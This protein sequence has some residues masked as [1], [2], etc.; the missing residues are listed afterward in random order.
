MTGKNNIGTSTFLKK[1]LHFAPKWWAMA[2]TLA[3]SLYAIYLSSLC[4]HHPCLQGQGM[5]SEIH[6]TLF[7]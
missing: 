5:R 6:Q 2:L 3:L 7:A 4:T 1:L